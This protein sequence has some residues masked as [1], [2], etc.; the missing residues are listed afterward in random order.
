MSCQEEE[1]L[2]AFRPELRMRAM[3]DEWCRGE[4][5]VFAGDSPARTGRV[6]VFKRVMQNIFLVSIAVRKEAGSGTG[7]EE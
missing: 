7:M 3:G 2:K 1:T 4:S 6:P 5:E